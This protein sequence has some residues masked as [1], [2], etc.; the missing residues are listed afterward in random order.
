M[1]G[2]MDGSEFLRGLAQTQRPG[3]GAQW[4]SGGAH[5]DGA[6]R[7]HKPVQQ[8]PNPNRH[9]LHPYVSRL[10]SLT[11]KKIWPTG[12]P[13]SVQTSIPTEIAKPASLKRLAHRYEIRGHR[14][15]RQPI[16]RALICFYSSTWTKP[17]V[18]DIIE[19][20]PS[21]HSPQVQNLQVDDESAGQRLDNFLVRHLKGAPKIGRAHV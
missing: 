3:C 1:R 19:P 7:W 20:E 12:I 2:G 14:P 5:T 9:C 10:R 13:L 16:V 18:K 21:T 4:F 17:L 15:H 6:S 8:S 11:S